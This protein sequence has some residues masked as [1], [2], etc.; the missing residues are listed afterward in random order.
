MD[1]KWLVLLFISLNSFASSRELKETLHK[2]RKEYS[3]PS[4]SAAFL[5]E[6]ELEEIGTVGIRK[7]GHKAKTTIKDKHHIGSCG[8]SMTATL[9]A[10]L[11]EKGYF[12]WD[13]T[14][15]ELLPDFQIHRSLRKVTLELLLSHF[16]GLVENPGEFSSSS[17]TIKDRRIIAKKILAFPPKY[18]PKKEF[19]YSNTGYIIVGH[20]MESLTKTSW[21][22][23]MRK[24]L[25]KPLRMRTCGFGPTSKKGEIIPSQPWG[26]KVINGKITPIQTDNAP[27]FGPAGTIHCSLIDWSKYLNMHI[28]GFNG[29]SKFLNR[30]SFKKL[31]TK[32]PVEGNHYTYGGWFRLERSWAKGAVLTHT[33]SNTLNFANVWVAPEVQSAIVSTTNFN[34]KSREATNKVIVEIIQRRLDP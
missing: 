25:F 33:G 7:V 3:L 13:S 17:S 16:S 27:S 24:F 12:S 34:M 21:E 1:F 4:L 10:L 5:Q 26:H 22:N 14:L 31:Y 19:H 9:A 6:G 29:K 30:K 11:I 28:N 18:S 2:V 32:F 8:K 15:E 20:I 23:L